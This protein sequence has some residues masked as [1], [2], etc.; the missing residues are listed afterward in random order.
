[1]P[2]QACGKGGQHPVPEGKDVIVIRA[3][4]QLRLGA[5]EVGDYL[6]IV[7]IALRERSACVLRG[8]HLGNSSHKGLVRRADGGNVLCREGLVQSGPGLLHGGVGFRPFAV[9]ADDGQEAVCEVHAVT[10]VVRRGG[11]AALG[12]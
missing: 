5:V 8:L 3:L 9:R 1:M 4:I 2:E 12:L 7:V 6:V 10:E 11:I